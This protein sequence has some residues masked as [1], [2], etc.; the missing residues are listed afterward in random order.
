MVTAFALDCPH[1]MPSLANHATLS[2]PQAHKLV[3][4]VQ[5][6]ETL[7]QVIAWGLALPTERIILEVVV[8]DEYTHDVVIEWELGLHLVFDTT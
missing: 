4:E 8:Q 7:E 6:L 5:G 2:E 1:P 3:R